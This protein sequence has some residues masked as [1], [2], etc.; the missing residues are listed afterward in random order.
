LVNLSHTWHFVGHF[1][2]WVVEIAVA[3]G[4]LGRSGGGFLV[5]RA[6]TLGKVG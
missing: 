2:E 5:A 3:G 4:I 6:K 1:A